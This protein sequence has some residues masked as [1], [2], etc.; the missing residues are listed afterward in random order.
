VST[1]LLSFKIKQE[2]GDFLGCRGQIFLGLV[3]A[4]VCLLYG[5]DKLISLISVFDWRCACCKVS[6]E[7]RCHRLASGDQFTAI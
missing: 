2:Y 5:G 1:N 4:V 6:G 3:L 7:I